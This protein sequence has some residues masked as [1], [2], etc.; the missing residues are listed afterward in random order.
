[1]T[2]KEVEIK[3][4]LSGILLSQKLRSINSW[5]C[6]MNPFSGRKNFVSYTFQLNVEY[7]R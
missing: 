2:G 6:D 5:I 4:E 1:M 7:K 3:M